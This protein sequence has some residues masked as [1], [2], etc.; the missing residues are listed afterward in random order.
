VTELDR[1]YTF[2]KKQALSDEW[3]GQGR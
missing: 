3:A 2:M 1:L